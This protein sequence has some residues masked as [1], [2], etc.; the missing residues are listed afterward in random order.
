MLITL[1]IIIKQSCP[2]PA[3]LIPLLNLENLGDL[4]CV[5]QTYDGASVMSGAVGG[6]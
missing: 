6:V 2:F 3:F 4:M 5:A 1:S